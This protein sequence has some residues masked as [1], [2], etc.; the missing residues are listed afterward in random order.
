MQDLLVL[1]VLGAARACIVTCL[2]DL[3]AG[4]PSKSVAVVAKIDALI[5][6]AGVNTAPGDLVEELRARWRPVAAVRFEEAAVM[7]ADASGLWVS[8]WL[9]TPQGTPPLALQT[10]KAALAALPLMAREVYTLHRM[11]GCSFDEIAD[12]LGLA[13]SD[14]EKLFFE[15]LRTLHLQ[16][17]PCR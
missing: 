17:Y 2:S 9:L 16:I 7:Q 6:R 10:F 12:R 14:V 15:A 4:T 8:A 13:P 11:D 3:S 1:E 5:A